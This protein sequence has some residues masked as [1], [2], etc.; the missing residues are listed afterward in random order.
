MGIATE[1]ADA[2][3]TELNAKTDWRFPFH[4]E[5][6]AAV[7]RDVRDLNELCVSVIPASIDY[8][9]Q[10]R[11]YIRSTVEI[12]IGVQKHLDGTES[13]PVADLGSLVDQIA[14]YLTGRKL[15]HKPNAKP[16]GTANEPIYIQEHLLQKSVFTS[17]VSL[18]YQIIEEE[19]KED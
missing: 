17:V 6:I 12:D 8:A 1:L 13:D 14:R 2:V 5:R 19:A 4:A 10:A 3:V 7:R 15:S 18:K 16:I 11:D 9:R